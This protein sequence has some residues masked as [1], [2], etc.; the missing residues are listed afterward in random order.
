[1]DPQGSGA[2]SQKYCLK[3]VLESRPIQ[4][5]RNELTPWRGDPQGLAFFP[6]LP[7]VGCLSIANKTDSFPTHI[8][9][10]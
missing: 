7:G 5:E 3:E 6:L 2:L 1:M 8:Y 9:P 10:L 4:K